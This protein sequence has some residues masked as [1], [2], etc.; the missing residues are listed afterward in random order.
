MTVTNKIKEL[1]VRTG[2]FEDTLKLSLTVLAL[3]V[4][5]GFC[6]YLYLR[7][8]NENIRCMNDMRMKRIRE[9]QMER[10]EK[11][12]NEYLLNPDLKEKDD[13][14]NSGEDDDNKRKKQ[15][16]NNFSRFN[17]H[18]N[19][20]FSYISTYRPSVSKRYPCKKCC[21]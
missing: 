3:V 21:G 5:M 9:K 8:R 20:H 4:T 2:L 19:P 17:N 12:R 15:R 10:W 11:E 6:Y 14:S 13:N 16:S 7:K 18:L 1:L